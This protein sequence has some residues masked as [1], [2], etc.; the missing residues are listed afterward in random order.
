MSD[1][2]E[3]TAG[4]GRVRVQGLK[5]TLRQLSQAG[6]DAEDMKSLMHELG[7]IVVKAANPPERSGTLAGT[8]RA[9]RGKTKAVVR[10]GGAR[11]RYAGVIHYGW[12][13][14]NI[15]ARPFL[16]DALQSRRAEIFRTLDR[17]LA[18]ILRQNDLT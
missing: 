18:D 12:P 10:A 6:A 13:A 11:A 4:P 3:L 8:I 2:L 1:D 7:E 15:A 5:R 17:G 16:T 9:G 14:R